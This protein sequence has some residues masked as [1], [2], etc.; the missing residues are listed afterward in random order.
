MADRLVGQWG[1]PGF[2]SA[3]RT[4]GSTAGSH[5]P[6][7]SPLRCRLRHSPLAPCD[8][9]S[10]VASVRAALASGHAAYSSRTYSHTPHTYAPLRHKVFCSCVA[11]H[12]LSALR[13]C[14]SG[15]GSPQRLPPPRCGCALCDIVRTPD[16]VGGNQWGWWWV[17]KETAC[18]RLALAALPQLCALRSLCAGRRVAGVTG[19]HSLPG[20]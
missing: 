2:A 15:S 16:V 4:F 5:R 14:R 20:V 8:P 18:G 11:P 3:P 7:A 12:C 1:V 10:C 19:F 13:C 6:A 9:P 17:L